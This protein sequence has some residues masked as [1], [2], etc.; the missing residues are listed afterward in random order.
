MKKP[1]QKSVA[2]VTIRQARMEDVEAIHALVTEFAR[3]GT[4]LPRSR[5]ERGL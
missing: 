4:M 2:Q 3:R 5:A 1:R